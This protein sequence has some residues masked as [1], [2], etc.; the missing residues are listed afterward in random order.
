MNND[1]VIAIE[2]LARIL[3][4]EDEVVRVWALASLA[5]RFGMTAIVTA[6]EDSVDAIVEVGEMWADSV[7]QQLAED[8]NHATDTLRAAHR[9]VMRLLEAVDC[10]VLAA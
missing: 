9:V 6:E 5:S 3:E 4:H 1:I 8:P 10:S 7:D 2:N